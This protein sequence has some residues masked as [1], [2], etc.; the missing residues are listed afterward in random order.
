MRTP[1]ISTKARSFLRACLLRTPVAWERRTL[2]THV[3][4]ASY[5]PSSLRRARQYWSRLALAP[6]CFSDWRRRPAYFAPSTQTCK[7][8]QLILRGLPRHNTVPPKIAHKEGQL[9]IP[10]PCADCLDIVGQ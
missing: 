4:D 3:L 2:A 9:L 1:R 10:L 6:T 7:G 8:N 5:R